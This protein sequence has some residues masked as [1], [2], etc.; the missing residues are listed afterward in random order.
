MTVYI[1]TIFLGDGRTLINGVY[2]SASRAERELQRVLLQF[3]SIGLENL[4][5]TI[6]PTDV[7]Q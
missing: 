7:V 5:A 1:L 6:T 3:D 4:T 2:A